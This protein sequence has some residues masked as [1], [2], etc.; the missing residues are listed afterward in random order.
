LPIQI[1]PTRKAEVTITSKGEAAVPVRAPLYFNNDTT[2]GI[3]VLKEG[4]T[5]SLECK[6]AAALFCEVE[7]M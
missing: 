2:P 5:L 3:K 7:L 4:A 1:D 6:S